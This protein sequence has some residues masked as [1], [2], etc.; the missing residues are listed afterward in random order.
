MIVYGLKNCDTCRKAVKELSMAGHSVELVD[1]SANPLAEAQISRFLE[2]FGDALVN[3]RSTTWRG[4]SE[5]ERAV[6]P[7]A[8]LS[9]H[10]ALMKRPVIDTGATLYL[11]WDAASKSALL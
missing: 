1:I 2:S 11:G 10:P 3:R 9:D 5:A 4:L 8:L 6:A 7:L